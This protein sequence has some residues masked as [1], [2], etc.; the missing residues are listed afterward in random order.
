MK[1]EYHGATG[2]SSG[3]YSKSRMQMQI[4]NYRLET[5]YLLTP[6]GHEGC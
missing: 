4:M 1:Y 3:Y 2:F 6:R 5:Y